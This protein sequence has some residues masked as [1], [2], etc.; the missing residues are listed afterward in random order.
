MIK[1]FILVFIFIGPLLYS[2]SASVQTTASANGA[3]TTQVPNGYYNVTA[4][5]TNGFTFTVSS[6]IDGGAY[7]L[8]GNMDG[9]GT[10]N[11]IGSITNNPST[12]FTF[13]IDET[14]INA[15]SNIT[16][17]SGNQLFF[18]IQSLNAD[19]SLHGTVAATVTSGFGAANAFYID[20]T[21]PVATSVNDAYVKTGTTVT[22]T[23]SG[24]ATPSNTNKTVSIDGNTFSPTINSDTEL[25]FQVGAGNYTGIVIV[26]D[27]AGNSNTAGATLTVDNISPVLTSVTPNTA[28]KNGSTASIVGSGF[29]S[30]PASP[31]ATLTIN[32]ATTGVG[33]FL[34]IDETNITLTAG[35]GD[36]STSAIRVTDEAGNT[37]TATNVTI[38]IDNT[39]PSISSITDTGGNAKALGKEGDDREIRGSGFTNGGDPT[40]TIGGSTLAT[41]GISA[42]YTSTKITMTLGSTE[43]TN[44]SVVV[45][46]A[47]G[48]V[49]TGSTFTIDNTLPTVTNVATQYIKNGATSIITGTGFT[50]NGNATAVSLGGTDINGT[51]A[52]KSIDSNTQITITGASTDFTD[53]NVT[54][55]DAAGNESTDTGKL[56]TIDASDPAIT[57]IYPTANGNSDPDIVKSGATIT[58]IGSGFTAG[59]G[60]SSSSA[61]LQVLINDSWP[62][63]MTVSIASTSITITAGSGE[64]NGALKILDNAGNSATD[65]GP[66]VIDNTEPNVT[67]LSPDA[68]N[69][70]LIHIKTGGSITVAGT[71]FNN[72][73][74]GSSDATVKLGPTNWTTYGS[75]TVDNSGQITLADGS[76]GNASGNLIITDFAGNAYTV[77]DYTVYVDNTAPTVSSVTPKAIKS[78]ATAIVTGVG[79]K[80][81]TAESTVTVGGNASG[82]TTFTYTVDSNTQIT[83]TGGTGDISDGQIVVTDPADNA[84]TDNVKLTVDNTKPTI[85]SIGTASIKSGG[86]SVVTGTGFFTTVDG[87]SNG[88]DLTVTIGG[89]TPAGMTYV[90]D[91]NTQITITAGSGEVT[92]L[93]VV[94]TDRAGNA[95]TET[96]KLL[97][98]DNTAPV[99]T[100]VSVASIKSSGTTTVSGS[101]FLVG[102]DIQNVKVGGNVP[103]GMTYA[104]V[105]SSSLI[106]TAGSGEVADGLVT[107][108]DAAGNVSTSLVYLT[109]DNSLPTVS[110]VATTVIGSG[111]TSVITGTDFV[112]STPNSSQTIEAMQVYVGGSTPTGLTFTVSSATSLSITAGSGEVTAA[113]ITVKDSAGNWSTSTGQNLTIDNTAPT[114][115][116]ISDRWIKSGETTIITGIGFQTYGGDASAITIGGIDLATAV[117]SSGLGG[118]FVVNSDTKITI[119]AGA[120]EVTRGTVIVIDYVG[121]AS[122]SFKEISIDNTAPNPPTTFEL[123]YTDSGTNDDNIS[124]DD[125][126]YFQYKGVASGDSIIVKVTKAGLV[127][128][129]VWLGRTSTTSN[130][131]V[132]EWIANSD[133]DDDYALL[134][135]SGPTELTENGQYTFA[136]FAIDSAGNESTTS[137]SFKYT[138]DNVAPSKPILSAISSETNGGESTTD[139]I[140]NSSQPS[141]VITNVPVGYKVQIYSDDSDDLTAGAYITLDDDTTRSSTD[142]V[143][144]STPLTHDQGLK[145]VDGVDV[146]EYEID[147]YFRVFATDTAGNS[148]WGD[149]VSPVEIDLAR[150]T[151]A[152]SY[153]INPVWFGD[154][155]VDITVKFNDNMNTVTKPKI[156]IY[157]PD[158]TATILNTDMTQGANDS[159]WTYQL[160]LIPNKT[161]NVR[162]NVSATDKAGNT[163]DNLA[164]TD[165]FTLFLDNTPP[166]S[167]NI[168]TITALGDTSVVGWFNDATDSLK[169]IIPLSS[170]D[171]TLLNGGKLRIE[172]NIQAKMADT[173]AAVNNNAGSTLDSIVERGTAVSFFRSRGNILSS[174]SGTLIQGDTIQFRATVFDRAGASTSGLPSTSVFVLDTIPPT[175]GTYITDTLFTAGGVFYP[176]KV[177]LDTTW[178][179]DTISFGIKDWVDPLENNGNPSGVGRFEY[180]VYESQTNVKNGSY[181]LFRTFRKQ[182][183]QLDTVFTDTFALTHD[184]YYYTRVQAID[185][186]GN[187]SV[188]N[189]D[190]S[191]SSIVYRH[192]AYPIAD[193]VPD[194]VAKE[195]ILWEQL[196][197]VNDKDLLTLRS[198]VFT[199]A[200]TTMKL[201]TTS[202]PIDSAVV[203]GLD[204]DVSTSGKV[205]FTPTKL[206]T[207]DY[208]F[209]VIVTDN[210]TLKDTVDINITAAPVND[211]PI[212]DLS[213]IIKLTFL[214]GANSDSINLTQFSYDEDN[215]TTD[216]KY[217]FRI[218]STLPGKGGFPTAKIGFLSDF[219]HEYKQSFVSK[220]VDEFPA[221]TII[222]KNNTFLVYAGEVDQFIDPIKVDSL[223]LSD[224]VFTWLTPTN[225]ASND[226]NYYTS[227][228][229][230]VE[231]TVIDPDGLED[232]DTVSFFINPINDP[233]VWSG[234]PDTIITE[235]DSL[236]FDFANYLT[237]VDDSTLT[238]SILPLTFG[239]NISIVP[240]KAYET[241]ASGIE[242]SSNAHIDTVKFK[243]DTL[244]FGPTG[245]WVKNKTDS[246]LIQITAADGDTSAIDTFVV[247]VQRVPRPE[248]RMYVVQNNAFTNYYEIFLVDSVGKTKDL[249]LKVQSKAVTLDTAAAFTYV[250]HYNFKTKGTYTFEVAAN[251]VVGDTTITQNLGLALAKM[252]GRWS[253]RSADGQF[254]VIGRNGAVD[255]DQSIMIL[256]ST[257]FE[258][259]FNDRAS[260]LLGNE[261]FRFK[262]SVEISMP[263]QDDEMALYQRS[264]GTGWIELPSIT[265]GNRVMAYTEKMGY[266]RMGPK[267]LIVPGQTA[268]QQNYP[269]PFN[270]ITT[271]EYDLGFVDGPLQKVTLTVYDILGR[272]VRVLVNQQQGIGRYRLKWNGKDQNGVP[273]SSGI[274][275]VHLLTNMGRSQTKKIMLMR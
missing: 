226:T 105:T 21:A 131:D 56:L 33:S 187:S 68:D 179:N 160:S 17:A 24:F 7:R 234:V 38:A 114:I 1:K 26:T 18:Q 205:T 64:V 32:N 248:I 237:D 20:K 40:V 256:D 152:I 62:T 8:Q 219:T 31:I 82:S 186:A 189:T 88:T 143:T 51:N 39:N 260:Y 74:I 148:T 265:Q 97:T 59:S 197:T 4:S 169:F 206:D 107:I 103:T 58:V 183:I 235:N 145:T 270:P 231:F 106:L 27:I 67:S 171:S 94:V 255:F 89:T 69:D 34:V 188:I 173:W 53:A 149:Q 77:S 240:T 46:D 84:S 241:K 30:S 196:L 98:I 272:N 136:A 174:L 87:A 28:I 154:N 213:S 164:T 86:T 212:L 221:S 79:F 192:N 150:D 170:T 267:T 112:T 274:Y 123:W 168:G 263:G 110:N 78:S 80:N 104:S 2:Q 121:N 9:G 133:A 181:D 204:A 109:I 210:W 122:G 22:L 266:F 71:G 11:N 115:T 23:G 254:N 195:D 134:T 201:D 93:N 190:A 218:V 140:T 259:Y 60:T 178:T 54:V 29:L 125:T 76:G 127:T 230:E 209:R 102:G 184:R 200:L 220:L 101:G 227:S 5:A 35:T 113:N 61:D 6:F 244:W 177:N 268:L 120:G 119:T 225:P 222:Q 271:I 243:P 141:F 245:P 163:N 156:N 146:L 25:T 57:N 275:F 73:P 129:G 223:V 108:T 81:G 70:K 182:T 155:T 124:Y 12:A 172:A 208:V 211:P 16:F 239:N 116:S 111:Q 99:L 198:D 202:T 264:T 90:V 3:T 13:T 249:T 224:S 117:A 10:W 157:W 247:R 269:N 217:T 92:E 175:I 207:A 44:G 228:D 100:G 96:G 36:V 95:S 63:G 85:T 258:P 14:T 252:Y 262:K 250:G 273:V 75:V 135:A 19:F 48:N 142:T 215:D 153:S 251:G 118:S 151:A 130:T 42:T 261:A 203:T 15:A 72:T 246:T 45:T 253:G 126:P 180:G 232:K 128:N 65:A 43:V 229:M 139:W 199:Y 242:Y 193:A 83:I 55:T 233:P 49:G 167:S 144:V 161:G 37:S 165:T 91:S 132:L 185:V 41:L 50:D 191:K 159:I 176:L 236:Y 162:I 138:F 257:L 137:T 216:L 158:T 238:I 52:I 214:E 66:V 147:R 47:A 166:D 194:T